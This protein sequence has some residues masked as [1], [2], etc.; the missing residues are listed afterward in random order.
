[1][2]KCDNS[3][4][5]NSNMYF[6]KYKWSHYQTTQVIGGEKRWYKCRVKKC[7]T[8]LKLNCNPMHEEEAANDLTMQINPTTKNKINELQKLGIKPSHILVELRNSGYDVPT[9]RQLTNHLAYMRRINNGAV[10]RM[11]RSQKETSSYLLQAGAYYY[12]LITPRKV[13]YSQMLPIN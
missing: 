12:L 10:K 4:N 1:M 3:C 11:T 9:T 8:M 13:T 5:Q 6:C 2:R 7:P